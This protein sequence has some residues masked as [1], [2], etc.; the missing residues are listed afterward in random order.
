M[1]PVSRVGYNY[2]MVIGNPIRPNKA[3][4]TLLIKSTLHGQVPRA[5]NTNSGFGGAC[6]LEGAKRQR[7]IEGMGTKE[8]EQVGKAL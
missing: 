2:F 1:G 5:M 4:S 6:H 8:A 7:E 3:P